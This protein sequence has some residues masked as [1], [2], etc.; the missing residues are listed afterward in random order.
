MLKDKGY[1]SASKILKEQQNVDNVI[2]KVKNKI[3]RAATYIKE[4]STKWGTIKKPSKIEKTTYRRN[5]K[6]LLYFKDYLTKLEHIK[7]AQIT[8]AK[9]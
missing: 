5:G 4:H 7:T 8:R 3:D 2:N 6:E 1:D 9:A